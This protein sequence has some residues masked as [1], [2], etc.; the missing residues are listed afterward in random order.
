MPGIYIQIRDLETRKVVRTLAN[1]AKQLMHRRSDRTIWRRRFAA[2][3]VFCFSSHLA[4]LISGGLTPSPRKPCGL[5]PSNRRPAFD[6]LRAATQLLGWRAMPIL[7][8][9]LIGVL[10]KFGG[11]CLPLEY[12][13]HAAATLSIPP[14]LHRGLSSLSP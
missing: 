7:K 12:S 10:A 8:I 4:G 9:G 13:Q 2:Y 11:E 5:I 3:R 6:D 1:S 14:I